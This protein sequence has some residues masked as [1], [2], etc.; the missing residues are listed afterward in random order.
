MR[1]GKPLIDKTFAPADIADVPKAIVA[2]G[3]WL[4][5]TQKIKLAA[6]VPSVDVNSKPQPVSTKMRR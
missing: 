2:A 5:E 3:D 6:S 4:R 1:D